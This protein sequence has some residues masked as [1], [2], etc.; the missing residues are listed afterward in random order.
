VPE[1]AIFHNEDMLRHDTG[2]NHP[3]RPERLVAI[4]EAIRAAQLHG[5]DWRESEPVE[6]ILLELVHPAEYVAAIAALEGRSALLDEDTPVS[7]MSV[8]AA[9]LAAGG[10][11]DAVDYV[12]AGE[13]RS[14][15]ALGRPPGHHAETARA[16]G[17][18]LFN[19]VA[20]AAATA[21]H[22]YG[23]KRVLVLDWDVHHGNGTQEIFYE[24]D[25]VL[26]I[27]LHQH[28]LWPGTGGDDEQGRGKGEGFTVNFP[29]PAGTGNDIYLG[30]FRSIITPIA[31]AYQPELILIS[32]GFDAHED[33]PLGEMDMTPEGYAGLCAIMHNLA[34]ELCNGRFV[35]SL[36]GGY[37]LDGLAA[38]VLACARV[39]NGELP[40]VIEPE[41]VATGDVMAEFSNHFK[42]HWPL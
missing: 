16:M 15:F 36:E 6:N 34:N 13:S 12:L 11:V 4:K 37:G 30:I 1:F 35:L 39:L 31:R 9:R 18:C 8:H 28:P 17:F 22:Q 32:A 5:I 40:D 29:L 24:R 41:A 7:E 2:P 33:D 38:S 3:E 23:L 14:A 21:L 10:A 19:N 42:A 20:V 25:D 27:D 26:F